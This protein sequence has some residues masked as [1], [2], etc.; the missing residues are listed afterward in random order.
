MAVSGV[1]RTG[2]SRW[3]MVDGW[4]VEDRHGCLSGC[5]SGRPNG[6]P[7]GVGCQRFGLVGIRKIML[8]G[9]RTEAG[10]CLEV[11]KHAGEP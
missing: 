10:I 4:I 1:G 8:L 6:R 3:M 11:D 9:M 2:E 7:S 5:P